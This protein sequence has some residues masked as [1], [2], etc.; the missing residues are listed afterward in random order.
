MTGFFT[1]KE[2]QSQKRPD[3]KVLSCHACGLYRKVQSPK[4]QPFGNFKKGIMN[5]GEAPTENDDINGKHWQ[6]QSGKFLKNTYAKLGVDLFEDCININ[7]INCRPVKSGKNRTPANFEIDC[8]RRIVLD[9]IKQYKPKVIIL[10][11]NSPLQ[12]VIGNRWKDSLDGIAK[13]RGWTIPD[14][15]LKCWICPT[16]HPS[17]VM[18]MEKNK[19]IEVVWIEDLGRAFSRV[20]EPFP[21]F[22]EPKI[23]ELTDLTALN[24]IPNLSTVAIDYE[25]TG[26]KPHAKGHRIVTASVATNEDTVYVFEMPKKAIDRKPFVKLL[27]NK[28]IKKIAQNMKFEHTWS[29]VILKTTVRNWWWDTMLATHVLDNRSGIT[30]LKFQVYVRF[31]VIDY[32]ST[33]EKALKAP[34]SNDLNQVKQFISKPK[35]KA[36]MLRYN[37]LD[38][39][40]EYRLAMLQQKL[41]NESIIPF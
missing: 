41:I 17:Y 27:K 3:G 18:Q 9:A 7:A 24:K 39:I 1:I 20:D 6:G 5:I 21:L 35:N 23:I 11:G 19:G 8:C 10:F 38:S 34:T 31:G 30:G 32:N 25:T 28:Y 29:K 13:W 40:F 22:K 2:T 14:Q 15:E 16:L 36:E 12:S 37:A 4:M 26:L 33:V